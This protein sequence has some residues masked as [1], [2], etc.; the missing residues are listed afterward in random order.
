VARVGIA[1]GEALARSDIE[2]I[3]TAPSKGSMPP[4]D[5]DKGNEVAVAEP[6]RAFGCPQLLSVRNLLF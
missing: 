3:V 5:L 1:A 2:R 6:T 4:L